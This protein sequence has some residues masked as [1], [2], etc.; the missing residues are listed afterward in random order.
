MPLPSLIRDYEDEFMAS[1]ES[2]RRDLQALRATMPAPA[3]NDSGETPPSTPAAPIT[4]DRPAMNRNIA[5]AVRR[6]RDVLSNREIE[7]TQ[8]APE[9]RAEVKG[10]LA[11]YKATLA[12]LDKDAAALKKQAADA[13]RADL[14]RG[15]TP[16][17]SSGAGGTSM[18]G[19][20]DDPE[21]ARMKQQLAR[22]TQTMK[23]SSKTLRDAEKL[24]FEMN[25]LADGT[26]EELEKQRHTIRSISDT[27]RQ[28]DEELSQV[29]RILRKMHR[30]MLKNKLMLSGIIALL[31]IMIIGIL[32]YK[33]ASPSA[34]HSDDAEGV[35]HGHQNGGD[36][37]VP[38]LPPDQTLW[39]FPPPPPTAANGDGDT[40]APLPSDAPAPPDARRLASR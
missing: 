8:A 37:S 3:G 26:L 28:T 21:T 17:S 11:G 34:T 2:V 19:A 27:T 18:A 4:A 39:T 33:F 29:Q 36:H 24:T 38:T 5:A 15:T 23:S 14:L 40:L 9:V 31:L 25:D 32:Y 12:A 35:S 10:R 7:A 30:E 6:M 13:D 22:N 1:S 16:S 20:S